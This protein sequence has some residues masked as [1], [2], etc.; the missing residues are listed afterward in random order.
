MSGWSGDKAESEPGHAPGPE[1]PEVA[2]PSCLLWE[3]DEGE[4]ELTAIGLATEQGVAAVVGEASFF[5]V[6]APS[7][8]VPA[9]TGAFQIDA[10]SWL[11]T[12]PPLP[13]PAPRG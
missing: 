10:S 1:A 5:R 3:G 4:I 12:P 8:K 6:D 2:L 7:K 13:D 9:F 11:R